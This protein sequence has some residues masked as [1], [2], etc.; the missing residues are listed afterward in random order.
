MPS[1]TISVSPANVPEDG[2]PNLVYTVT[3]NQ[4]S[5]SALSVGYTIGGTA[6]SGA[7]KERIYV[8]GRGRS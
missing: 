8:A 4:A 1:A 3:L 7:A 5:F 2:A 6:K